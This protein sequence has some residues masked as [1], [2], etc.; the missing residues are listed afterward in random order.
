MRDAIRHVMSQHIGRTSAAAAP[1]PKLSICAAVAR[2]SCAHDD[3]W[4]SRN[5]ERSSRATG[6]ERVGVA[7]WWALACRPT[8]SACHQG[9]LN[10]RNQGA[11][12]VQSA[13]N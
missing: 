8:S 3:A 4:P 11:L 6:G 12:N 7:P 5:L 9:A 2:A 13:Y 1:L 10:V